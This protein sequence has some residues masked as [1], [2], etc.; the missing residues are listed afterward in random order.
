[1]HTVKNILRRYATWIAKA[2]APLGPWGVFAIAAVDGSLLGMPVDAVVAGYVYFDRPH[3]LFYVLMAS[4][5][6]ALGSLVLYAVG[7]FGG[8]KVLRKRIPAER[9]AKIHAAFEG[10]E[11]W[12]LMLPAMLPPP[13]PFK[14]IV[15]AASA[16][17]MRLPNFLAAI[18]AGRCVRF[19]ILALLTIKF[20]PEFVHLAGEV[21][22]EHAGWVLAV[23]IIAAVGFLL[24]RRRRARQ[25]NKSPSPAGEQAHRRPAPLK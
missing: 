20:G 23:V 24:W 16:F 22:H 3:F 9:F 25:T 1:M 12:A 13:T 17:E 7:Y 19:L 21:I 8:E 6:S 14:L 18:F 15:L 10:N 4:A 11:F 2:L 5:G